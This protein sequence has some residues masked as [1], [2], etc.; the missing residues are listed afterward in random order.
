[1][2]LIKICIDEYNYNFKEMIK[3]AGRGRLKEAPLSIRLIHNVT[4][5]RE[6]LETSI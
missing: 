1:M 4:R 6:R 3:D 5:I 2:R